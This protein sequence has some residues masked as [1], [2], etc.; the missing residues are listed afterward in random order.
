MKKLLSIIKKIAFIVLILVFSLFIL[1]YAIYS[2][3]PEFKKR[4]PCQPIPKEII[5]NPEKTKLPNIVCPSDHPILKVSIT[6]YNLGKCG[7][8]WGYNNPVCSACDDPNKLHT[9]KAECDK[10][11]NRYYDSSLGSCV[12][13]E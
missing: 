3:F 1:V 4:S 5:W 12:L 11:P 9:I 6:H 13:K 7:G 2:A 8:Y 10:C